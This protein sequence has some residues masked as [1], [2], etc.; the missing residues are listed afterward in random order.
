ML[1]K[2]NYVRAIVLL[3]VGW[4]GYSL[5][6]LVFSMVQFLIGITCVYFFFQTQCFS[7][8][9]GDENLQPLSV[10]LESGPRQDSSAASIVH[11]SH[12]K[13]DE[14]ICQICLLKIVF[15]SIVVIRT[16][17]TAML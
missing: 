7:S 12:S 2:S 10:L 17:A 4:R 9:S 13:K 6:A 5:A 14:L 15:F 8:T 11:P 3:K 16:G 1:D